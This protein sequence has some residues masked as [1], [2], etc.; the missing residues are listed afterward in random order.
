MQYT[1]VSESDGVRTVGE[2][3]DRR[4]VGWHEVRLVDPDVVRRQAPSLGGE[5]VDVD[6]AQLTDEL[7][8][9]GGCEHR[10][11]HPIALDGVECVAYT[12][13]PTAAPRHFACDGGSGRVV[14]HAGPPP[15]RDFAPPNVLFADALVHSVV[16]AAAPPGLTLRADGRE[17][18]RGPRPPAVDVPEVVRLHRGGAVDVPVAVHYYSRD[19]HPDAPTRIG[20]VSRLVRGAASATSSIRVAAVDGGDATFGPCPCL[21]TASS[22][23]YDGA[24]C[25]ARPMVAWVRRDE[26]C[27]WTG[28]CG[29]VRVHDGR[30]SVESCRG[31][32]AAT[33]T[34]HDA[35]AGWSLLYS[36]GSA[37]GEG[38]AGGSIQLLG[39][40]RGLV[41][42][43]ERLPLRALERL[44]RDVDVSYDLVR[45]TLRL[46]NAWPGRMRAGPA[47]VEVDGTHVATIHVI[48][49]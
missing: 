14:V 2:V 9:V 19:L 45:I 42:Y 32:V 18:I 4:I 26:E 35:G 12:C 38:C 37:T 46:H 16:H 31:T 23:V 29:A 5:R 20:I 22:G 48:V 24:W 21:R 6:V 44:R 8:L 40:V 13:D 41:S 28:R 30:V 43:A 11:S 10:F 15:A 7:V 33:L 17:L 36:E 39:R 1:F 49:T 25:F 34:P 3:R 27:A 47:V